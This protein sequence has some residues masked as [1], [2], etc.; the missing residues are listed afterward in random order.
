MRQSTLGVFI[1]IRH[2]HL[3]VPVCQ[4]LIPIRIVL[5][6]RTI[7]ENA[8]INTFAL[9]LITIHAVCEFGCSHKMRQLAVETAST[10]R[11]ESERR[12]SVISAVIRTWQI[13]MYSATGIFAVFNHS[14]PHCVHYVEYNND[15]FNFCYSI[16]IQ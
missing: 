2:I 8:D 16:V 5:I 15:S 12:T 7:I 6:D 14:S 10:A 13:R 4:C 9:H 1:A 11:F 3:T